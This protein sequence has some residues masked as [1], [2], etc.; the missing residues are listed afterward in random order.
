MGAIEYNYWGKNDTHSY[1]LGHSIS[2]SSL[3]N[4]HQGTSFCRRS[5]F[6]WL[7]GECRYDHSSLSI[8]ITLLPPTLDTF[9]STCHFAKST[10]T[11]QNQLPIR[12]ILLW[13][14]FFLFSLPSQGTAAR[15][16]TNDDPPKPQFWLWSIFSLRVTDCERWCITDLILIQ[17]LKNTDV[18]MFKHSLCDILFKFPLCMCVSWGYDKISFISVSACGCLF[19]PSG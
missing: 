14:L 10:T 3:R 12:A 2:L 16:H 7:T 13:L 8:R 11:I 1:P 17:F 5:T 4:C 6:L 18:W 9:K 15:A 19:L